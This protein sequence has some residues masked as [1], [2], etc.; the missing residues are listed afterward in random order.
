MWLCVAALESV[1]RRRSGVG[2]GTGSGVSAIVAAKLDVILGGER[3]RPIAVAVACEQHSPQTTPGLAPGM[4]DGGAMGRRA[5]GL[6]VRSHAP[7][8]DILPR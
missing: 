6:L 2:L 1:A 3:Y 4:F 5:V 7:V 8:A